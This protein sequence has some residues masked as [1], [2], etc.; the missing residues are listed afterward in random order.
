MGAG[1]AGLGACR[2]LTKAGIEC[3][4]FE[5]SK[6]YGG[7]CATR[8][9]EGYTFD[10]GATSIA[11]RGKSLE[12]VM[13]EQL[14][15]SDLV[16]I[17]AP[18]Y[19]H[20]GLRISAGDAA[21]N[22]IERY[23][24]SSGNTKLAKLLADGADIRFET[25]VETL[26]KGTKGR[27]R[28]AGEAFD[29]VVLTPPAPQSMELLA[30]IGEFRPL[31]NVAYRPC[32]SVLLGYRLAAPSQAYCAVIEIEQRHPLTWLSLESVKS[33][34]RAPEGATAI[35]AQ[36]S[37]QFSAMHFDDNDQEIVDA[38]LVYVARLYGKEWLSP[39]VSGVKKWRY[40]QP[41]L[42]AMFDSVNAPIAR[43]VVAGDSVAGG[44][45]EYAYESG[46]RSAEHILRLI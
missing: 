38:T 35:V 41:E 10:T 33:P 32:L 5:K 16:R 44:R 28:I 29:F 34:N 24:Y 11:P 14:D 40:S 8:R 22:R 30:T 20:E 2:E 42:T 45:V 9:I 37:P 23:T 18:I 1:I 25:K 3:V 39:E 6:A 12:P 31:G 27:T 7:R 15:R 17:E 13:L 4:V 21:K 36:M 43:I 19:V 46:R 26:E